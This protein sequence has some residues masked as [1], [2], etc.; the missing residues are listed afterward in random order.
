MKQGATDFED[1]T[2]V[3]PD[4]GT[5]YRNSG[6]RSDTV[7]NAYG[8]ANESWSAVAE[9]VPCRLDNTGL[10]TANIQLDEEGGTV[11]SKWTLYVPYGTGLQN[12]DVF[13]PASDGRR[14]SVTLATDAAGQEH[15]E[16]ALLRLAEAT[17]LDGIGAAL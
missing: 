7:N 4:T 15:H 11:P 6:G 5:L 16:E 8:H 10:R 3:F 17:N 14:F 2:D 13:V 12:G 9:D 1:D